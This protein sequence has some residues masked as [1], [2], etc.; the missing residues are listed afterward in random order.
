MGTIDP[1]VFL[2]DP[3]TQASMDYVLNCVNE[4]DG[5]F[6]QVWPDRLLS[7]LI[8]VRKKLPVWNRDKKRNF[9]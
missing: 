7:E 4:V 2:D 1:R 9:F 6:T 5:E 3:S 8:I